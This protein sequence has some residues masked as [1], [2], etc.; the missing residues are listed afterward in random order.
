MFSVHHLP[1]VKGQ[2]SKMI[3]EFL[4]LQRFVS[5]F[6]RGGLSQPFEGSYLNAFEAIL[7]PREFIHAGTERGKAAA[8]RRG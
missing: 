6:P 1:L 2:P 8:R 5:F 7:N 3:Q 4:R